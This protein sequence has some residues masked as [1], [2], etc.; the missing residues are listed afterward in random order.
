MSALRQQMRETGREYALRVITERIINLQL[1]PGSMVS[2]SELADEMGLS[3]TPVREALIELSRIQIVTVYPQKGSSIALI[4]YA[5]VEE[6]RYIRYLLEMN[7]V[8]LVIKAVSSDDLN[9]LSRNVKLQAACLENCDLPR[10]MLL[11]NDF[12]KSLFDIARK[13]LVYQLMQSMQIH[14]DRVRRMSL[15]AVKDTKIVQDHQAILDAIIR[16]DAAAAQA[17][18]DRHLSRYQID[19]QALRQRYPGYFVPVEAANP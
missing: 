11:D 17:M 4:D 7:I 18:T 12:H 8:E 19:E 1:A 14:F 16:R 9:R 15:E 3:R 6:S 10:L 13:P 5:M 2:E